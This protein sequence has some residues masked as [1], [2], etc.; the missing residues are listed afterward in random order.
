MSAIQNLT[1]IVTSLISRL[2]LIE[3]N[4][5]KT[6]ELPAQLVLDPSTLLR[7]SRGGVSEKLSI[8]QIIDAI[9]N[10]NYNQLVSVNGISVLEE[11]GV[12]KI[13]IEDGAVWI[14][15]N[16]IYQNADLIE[17]PINLSAVG[18]NRIDILVGNNSNQIM[19]ISGEETEGIAVAP[20]TPYDTVFITQINVTD[21][22]V[23]EIESPIVGTQFRKKTELQSVVS[24]IS[25]ENAQLP[26]IPSGA[27]VYSLQNS[28]LVSISGFSR[29]LLTGASTDEPPYEG[30]EFWIY[31]NSA[32][33]ITLLY[34]AQPT[35]A[36]SISTGEDLVIPSGGKVMLKFQS[37]F[38]TEIF[39]S[40]GATVDLSG[41]VDKNTTPGVER[42]WVYGLDGVGNFKPTSELGGGGSTA[43]LK[44]SLF[45][46]HD[47]YLA[48]DSSTNSVWNGAIG[49][50]NGGGVNNLFV[51]SPN[52]FGNAIFNSGTNANG[53]GRIC[54]F[55]QL[56]KSTK[57]LYHYFEIAFVTH[58][59]T[60]SAVRLGFNSNA[61]FGVPVHGA[62]IEVLNN[63]TFSFKTYDNNVFTSS[64]NFSLTTATSLTEPIYYKCLVIFEEANQVRFIVRQDDNTLVANELITTNVP[65]DSRRFGGGTIAGVANA[66]TNTNLCIVDKHVLGID[67]PNFLT[68]ML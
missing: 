30:K 52:H 54:T 32:N 50:V 23:G 67:L 37:G 15:N 41:K 18:T 17:I 44:Q 11:E 13:L 9:Q 21:G 24:T 8:Q 48:N 45:Y 51:N 59:R 43:T 68:F 36:F 56:F 3:T 66:G 63:G 64:G 22:L 25:G 6:E 5:K 61:S 2:N 33:A 46:F 42:V 57:G 20:P 1:N 4:S 7:G 27:S 53:C 16:V 31:N 35:D 12:F 60:D 29:S 55:N 39:K 58:S 49:G 14:I 40:W 62:V 26:F 28:S 38:F 34:D 65:I 19:L 47:F 10:G